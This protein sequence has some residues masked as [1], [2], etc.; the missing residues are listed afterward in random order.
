MLR[1]IFEVM[2][3]LAVD[4]KSCSPPFCY[5]SQTI[6]AGSQL[7]VMS[8]QFS[9]VAVY[10][11]FSLWFYPPHYPPSLLISCLFS[12]MPLKGAP[13]RLVS[14]SIET[15]P[16]QMYTGALG[17]FLDLVLQIHYLLLRNGTTNRKCDTQLTQCNCSLNKDIARIILSL[18]LQRYGFYLCFLYK[19]CD[20]IQP[21]NDDKIVFPANGF[22]NWKHSHHCVKITNLFLSC[23]QVLQS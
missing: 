20:S 23:I 13:L 4:Q 10:L 22:D 5:L 9:S 7:T 12:L 18:F 11:I 6:S 1:I 2:I 17:S 16:N 3:Q 8:F 14:L 21:F 19:L 15:L